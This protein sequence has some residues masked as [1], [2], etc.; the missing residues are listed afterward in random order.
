MKSNKWLD[1]RQ[2]DMWPNIQDHI[3]WVVQTAG[4]VDLALE[5]ST[6]S[7]NTGRLQ[8]LPA[9]FPMIL[10]DVTPEG[11]AFGYHHDNGVM[12]MPVELLIPWRK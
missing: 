4:P 7:W 2:Q 6:A 10:K 11:Y 5:G 9:G 8:R 1:G 3:G 12:R